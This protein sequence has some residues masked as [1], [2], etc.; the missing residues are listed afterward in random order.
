MLTKRKLGRQGLEVST[1]GLGCMGMSHAYGEPDDAD[2]E[3]GPFPIFGDGRVDPQQPDGRVISVFPE[4]FVGSREDSFY[5][6]AIIRHPRGAG[7]RHIFLPFDVSEG[8]AHI[9]VAIDL[10]ILAGA[11][12]GQEK[13]GVAVDIGPRMPSSW[14]AAS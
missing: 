2:H 11:F 10:F 8:E 9:A 7:H 1:I 6:G 14:V 5:F 3:A 13:D 12:V 4:R